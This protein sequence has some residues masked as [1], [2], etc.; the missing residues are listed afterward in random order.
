M[1]YKGLVDALL[2]P[3]VR[4]CHKP[5][6]FPLLGSLE[7]RKLKNCLSGAKEGKNPKSC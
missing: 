6:L 5:L 7:E 2:V 4:Y 1:A 3:Q